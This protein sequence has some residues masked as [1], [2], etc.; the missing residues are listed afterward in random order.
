MMNVSLNDKTCVG[1]WHVGSERKK[2]S[3]ECNF[4]SCIS[5]DGQISQCQ[6]AYINS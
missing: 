2:K 1:F 6:M 3:E 4:K 5:G